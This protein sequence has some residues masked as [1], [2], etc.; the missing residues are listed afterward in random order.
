MFIL[1]LRFQN[2]LNVFNN[3]LQHG[4]SKFDQDSSLIQFLF[5]AYSLVLVVIFESRKQYSLVG[6][7]RICN[8][9]GREENINQQTWYTSDIA[10]TVLNK[11]KFL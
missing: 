11:I 8:N 3:S 1:T 10:L 5:C 4:K 7:S 2:K 9:F 6:L